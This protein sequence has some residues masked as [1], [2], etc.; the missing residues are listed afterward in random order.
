MNKELIAKLLRHLLGFAGGYLAA[1]GIEI[2]GTDMD[3]IAGG[4]AA[5]AA[6]AW[7]IKDA[8]KPAAPAAGQD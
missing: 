6:V 8:K 7:S 2:T 1:K 4:L 3:A 5:I